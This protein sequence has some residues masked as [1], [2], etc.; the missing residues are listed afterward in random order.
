MSPSQRSQDQQPV[1][2]LHDIIVAEND[3]RIR[4]AGSLAEEWLK[5]Y[6]LHENL[7][8][9]LPLSINRWLRKVA[10]GGGV[11]EL[12]KDGGRLVIKLVKGERKGP[13]CLL[14]EES[15]GAGHPWSGE[16]ARL[17]YRELEVLFWV[18]Q[19]KANWAIGKILNLSPGTVR[20]HL[21]HIYS[22]LGVENRTAAAL[23]LLEI[24]QSS[25]EELN[26]LLAKTIGRQA[27]DDNRL[28]RRGLRA[29]APNARSIG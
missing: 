8:Q 27:I 10:S 3:G 29:N 20:K 23:C 26:F 28:G 11:L 16:G 12:N 13:H 4:C 24:A 21:Q 2:D 18:A 5:K 19:G 15:H 7:S 1:G 17:T 6:S 25:S 9:R 14:L 22:K